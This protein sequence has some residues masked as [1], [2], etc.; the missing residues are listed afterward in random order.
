LW[1]YVVY[2]KALNILNRSKNVAINKRCVLFCW[3]NGVLF[4]VQTTPLP[5]M[6]M[7]F[8]QFSSVKFS[9]VQ[10]STVQF[11]SVQS[12][13]AQFSWVH[14]DRRSMQQ[15]ILRQQ[16]VQSSLLYLIIT[17]RCAWH[18]KLI[19]FC[20]LSH[21]LLCNTYCITITFLVSMHT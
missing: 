18:R 13:P 3:I 19:Q 10:S 16:F 2:D 11:S 8:G 14:Y 4:T 1:R 9:S 6:P 17:P 20:Q 12:S 5:L 21:L 7:M 15:V